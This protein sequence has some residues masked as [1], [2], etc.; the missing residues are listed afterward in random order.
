[1]NP[2]PICNSSEERRS[3]SKVNL[4]YGTE[5]DL[6]ECPSCAVLYFDP[7]PTTEELAAFYSA[8]YYNFERSREEGKGMTWAKQL[9]RL[10]ESGTFLDIGCAT[11]FFINGIRNH[12]NW[13][14][15]GTDFGESAVAYARE[16]LG[17][18]VRQGDIAEAGFED[19]FFDYVH[20][21][22]VLEHVPDPVSLLRECR[23]LVKP[24]GVFYLSVP[25]GY[26]DSLDL[27]EFH[28]QENKPARS[29]SGHIFF[30]PAATLQR[31]LDEAGFEIVD[32]KTYSFKRGF[33]SIGYLPRKKSWKNDLYP[34]EEPEVQV[35]DEV[36]IPEGP[37][38]HSNFYYHYRHYHE[39][40]MMLP[41]LHASGLDFQFI[42]KP[43]G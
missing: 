14:V 10:K 19:G 8:S 6:V 40:M 32:K 20:L 24:D 26:N 42:L 13:Q 37:P 11:G 17:L 43:K 7:M 12:S 31:M 2:C 22:N 25:N 34:R 38:E 33:R 18:D 3:I 35:S 39:R 28:R 9:R 41:G 29:K 16:H 21:N 27:I 36:N 5:Y 1:M 23:R 4:I 15:Y 30:F